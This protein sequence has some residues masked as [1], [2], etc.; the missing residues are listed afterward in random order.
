MDPQSRLAAVLAGRDG[1]HPAETLMLRARLDAE[2]GRVDEAVYGIR[3]AAAALNELPSA[4][5]QKLREQLEAIRRRVEA[6]RD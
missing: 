6:G 4:R 2:Q 5:D 1:V 3:A